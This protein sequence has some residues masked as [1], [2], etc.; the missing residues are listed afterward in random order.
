MFC[1]STFFSFLLSIIIAYLPALGGV[2]Q[3]VQ[4]QR[5]W[6]LLLFTRLELEP[7]GGQRR[8]GKKSRYR[9]SIHAAVPVFFHMP[10]CCRHVAAEYAFAADA[11]LVSE[12]ARGALWDRKLLRTGTSTRRPPNFPFC[13]F[14]NA[15][16]SCL[17]WY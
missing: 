11:P 8:R 7:V 6:V 12:R 16:C 3:P 5:P 4:P 15:N 10:P 13:V 2:F 17:S 14:L 1:L 9:T